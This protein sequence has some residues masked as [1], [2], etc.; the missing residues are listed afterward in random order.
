MSAKTTSLNHK[1]MI[2][3]LCNNLV[4]KGIEPNIPM[5]LSLIPEIKSTSTAHKHLLSW[6]TIR[7][8]EQKEWFDN[9]FALSSN[10]AQT[11]MDELALKE[12]EAELRYKNQFN[13]ANSQRL[14]AEQELSQ[15]KAEY[16][17]LS[18][19][20]VASETRI[21]LLERQLM[22]S[23]ELA[24]ENQENDAQYQKALEELTRTHS[25]AVK[26]LDTQIEQLR[27][28]N[29]SSSRLN[30]ELVEELTSQKALASESKALAQTL[31][32]RNE[33]L[34]LSNEALIKQNEKVNAELEDATQAVEDNKNK[35]NELTEVK[36]ALQNELITLK[37]SN[38]AFQEET[39]N[40]ENSN[41]D[42]S[43]NHINLNEI[44]ESEDKDLTALNDANLALTKELESV[45]AALKETDAKLQD[46]YTHK[47]KLLV[48]VKTQKT[49]IDLLCKRK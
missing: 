14:I 10:F 35:V 23:R 2:H 36:T 30:Q 42:I 12:K 44:V 20:Q 4:K 22:Q 37:A 39:N 8:Q 48:E 46:A 17:A 3:E 21:E 9:K 19:K 29:L 5:L 41:N 15:F 43:S 40:F 26:E 18:L 6:K 16:E 47:M 34:L 27:T 33:K 24:N 28:K 11:F 32:E 38:L 45:K 25:L 7:A 13:E 31:D 1:K 49:A